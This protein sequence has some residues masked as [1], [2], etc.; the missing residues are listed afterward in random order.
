MKQR[1]LQLNREAFGKV[2]LPGSRGTCQ[3]EY[4]YRLAAL[5]QRKPP[6]Y[7]RRDVITHRILADDFAL[8][9][10]R[11][12]LSVYDSRLGFLRQFLLKHGPIRKPVKCIHQPA[13]L[14]EIAAFVPLFFMENSCEREQPEDAGNTER[15][16]RDHV[17]SRYSDPPWRQAGYYQDDAATRTVSRRSAPMPEKRPASAALPLN[18]TSASIYLDVQVKHLSNAHD[19]KNGL[20]R[21]RCDA[22]RNTA[23]VAIADTCQADLAAQGDGNRKR[24]A[25]VR[26]H[27]G[28]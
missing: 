19:R 22:N 17:K 4:A 25:V 1:A 26:Q 23:A 11:Q 9:G 24:Y 8:Q 7:L 10:I 27:H 16:S 28:P 12:L 15:S 21:T 5:L 14:G 6:P 3:D 2:G 20:C 13:S 18:S